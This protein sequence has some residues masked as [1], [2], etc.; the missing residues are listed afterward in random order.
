MIFP[1]YCSTKNEREKI[2]F[3]RAVLEALATD[4]GLFVPEF[5]P[6]IQWKTWKPIDNF[7]KIA[8]NVLKCFLGEEFSN[9]IDE[10][11]QNS[12]RFPL[13][14]KFLD[15]HLYVLELF[16]GPTC[17]FKDF[18]ACFL[19][20]AFDLIFQ[21]RELTEPYTILVATSGDTGSAV[22]SAFMDNPSTQILLLFPEGQVS[23]RQ[24]QQLTCWGKN[25]FS[26]S[27]RGNFDDCQRLVK[28]AFLD[29]QWKKRFLLTSANSVNIGRLLPQVA[30]YVY[31]S[32][33]HYWNRGTHVS[34]VVPTGNMGNALAAFY[35]K[36]MGFPIDQIV[37]ATNANKTIVD[38]FKNKIWNPRKSIKTLA[39]AMDVGN[40]S[41]IERLFHL[42][43][44]KHK[45]IFS[46]SY[47][48]S[49]EN[50]EIKQTI[51]RIYQR[52][53]E[54]ICPHT[55]TAF[56]VWQ[57]MTDHSKDW[58]IVSTAHPA[59]FHDIIEPILNQSL[60]VPVSLEKMLDL[61]Q[62]YRTSGAD[63][64]EI[65]HKANVF[66]PSSIRTDPSF[67]SIQ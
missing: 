31:A 29:P 33:Q 13:K 50:F 25:I 57:D 23:E 51:Q 19:S 7:Q 1:S 28:S 46:H 8:A 17:A 5:F 36:T 39:N 52:F 44:R 2:S 35:A 65:Y 42:Y 53:G 45:E 3:S 30:Y 63:L 37:L 62:E 27:V 67:L 47:V 59:K 43:N 56:S 64:S 48:K 24:K 55:A 61:P 18:G 6:R 14:L 20:S 34:F 10:L 32:L 21:K 58:I 41:N 49:V 26:L 15:D 38:Y 16:H 4:G 40:P 66:F 22:A 12:F 60:P 54:F 9:N 11:C